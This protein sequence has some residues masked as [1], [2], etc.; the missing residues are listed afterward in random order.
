M[1]GPD[2]IRFFIAISNAPSLAAAA[3][4]LNVSAPAV[5]QRLRALEERLGVHLIDRVGRQLTLTND[6]ELL[7]ERGRG[8]LIALSELD[9]QLAERRG[10]VTGLLRIIA[11]LG[12]GRRYVAPVVAA[13]QQEYP[14]VKIDLTL[15]DRLTGVPSSSWDLAVQ[16][17][18]LNNTPSSFF[19]RNLAANTRFVCASPDYLET[20]G[21]PVVPND[22][23]RHSWIT[24]RENEE[25]VTLLKFKGLDGQKYR[26]RIHPNLTSNDGDVIR[27]WAIS[28]RGIIV[29]S[30]WDVVEDIRSGRL[31]RILSQYSLPEAPVT[32]LLG[33]GH[34]ARAARTGRFL[35]TLAKALNPIPWR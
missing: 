23:L 17:E 32:V 35:D 15:T 11:P 3:R 31:V 27:N 14:N 22:L 24:L 19:M 30:E 33:S 29:R 18:E 1:I 10:Q 21:T 12:F 6:G 26:I 9:E 25:D 7:V 5:T 20:Y 34:Q 13:F 2:D 16:V 8:V 28:G 4:A